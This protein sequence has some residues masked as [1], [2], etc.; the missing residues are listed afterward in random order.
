MIELR[1][2][3][4]GGDYSPEQWPEEHWRRDLD[5]FEEAGVNTLTLPVFAWARLQPREDLFDFAWLDRFLDLAGEKGFGI[6]LATPTASQPAWMSR[7][8]PDVLAVDRHGM[9]RSH[10]T[11]R[12]FCPNSETYRRFAETIAGKMAGRYGRHPAVLLWHVSNEYRPSCYCDQC[13]KAFRRWLQEKYHSLEEL[14]AALSLDF[15]GNTVYDWDEIIVPSD[16]NDGFYACQAVSLEYRRFMTAAAIACYRREREAIRGQPGA[17]PISTNFTGLIEP[18]DFFAWAE[19]L[20]VI[21]WDNY[22][23]P[24]D[25][26]SNV[27]MK[28]DIMRG[29]KRGEPFLLM[30]QSPSVQNWLPYNKLRPPGAL[31]LLSYQALAH[32]ADSVLMFQLKASLGGIETNHGAF[33][34]HAGHGDTRIFRECAELGRELAALKDK[35]VGSTMKAEVAM[36]VDWESCWAVELSSG[37]NKDLRYFDLVARF[38]RAFNE[39]N[40]PVD[41]VPATGPFT[42]YRVVVAPLLYLLSSEEAL[43][44]ETYV[45]DGGVL[46]TTFLTGV[47]DRTDTVV[48]GGCP[49]ALRNVVGLWVE[50]IDAYEPH[51]TNTMFVESAFAGLD[52]E[53]RCGTV[54]EILR[55]ESA[56]PLA[57]Y[58]ERFYSRNPCLAANR[59]GSGTAY[60]VAT[61]PEDTFLRRFA[62]AVCREHDAAVPFSAPEDVEVTRRYKHGKSYTFVLNYNEDDVEL[63]VPPGRVLIGNALCGSRI[64]LAPL[65]VAVIE[66]AVPTNR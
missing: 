57:S 51:E 28:H 4:Y 17:V 1:R 43:C 38:Y 19:H 13:A 2:I 12:N 32:G 42:D 18:V 59:C 37:P 44:I 6:C 46:V 8:Y 45:A 47:A 3:L 7:N 41:I 36:I 27:A 9:R 55:L 48:P 26:R 60:Y 25:H 33:V 22:P 15:W 54:C 63:D 53:Y 50:E 35:I 21:G 61:L 24:G 62:A 40:I 64:G 30:E 20:D 10:G 65:D 29:L 23:M 34:S 5:L 11:R 66:S 16:L 14:N 31:R 58:G 52:G 56:I 49:A 39:E